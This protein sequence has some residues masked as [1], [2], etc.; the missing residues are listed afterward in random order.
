MRKLLFIL[1][2]FIMCQSAK[3]Q[4]VVRDGD[5][6]YPAYCTIV[7]YNFWGFGKV[8]CMVDFGIST[9]WTNSQLRILDEKGNP[10]K[11]G[12]NMQAIDYLSKRGWVLEQTIFLTKG[13]SN[14]LHYIMKKM[15]KNDSEI[16]EGIKVESIKSKDPRKKTGDD[17]FDSGVD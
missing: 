1:A 3:A 4:D 14:V 2:L 12:S 5:G 13:S 15:V 6:R 7:M 9:D 10:M 8:K 16:T 17:M 11:F